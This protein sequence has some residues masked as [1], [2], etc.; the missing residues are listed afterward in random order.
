MRALKRLS[1]A[2]MLP[3]MARATRGGLCNRPCTALLWPDILQG[4]WA[5]MKKAQRSSDG[6]IPCINDLVVRHGRQENLFTTVFYAD[7]NFI[8]TSVPNISHK[9]ITC[10][11]QYINATEKLPSWFSPHRIPEKI[12]LFWQRAL[13]S[14]LPLHKNAKFL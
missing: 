13:H 14:S 11:E 12:L 2:S 8:A 6:H 7:R 9:T 1:R 5:E 10:L 4:H 3:G